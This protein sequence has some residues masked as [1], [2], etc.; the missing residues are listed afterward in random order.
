MRNVMLIAR[1]E[2]GGY[3]TTMLGYIVGAIALFLVAVLFNIYAVPGVAKKSSMVLSDFFI[4]A[5]GL[6]MIA[7][8]LVS[9]I[10]LL[11]EE[12]TRGTLTLL[13]ASPVRDVEIVFGKYLS[14]M[15]FMALFL[16][17]TF[18]MPALVL[19]YGKVSLGHI[20]CGYLG[21]LL[22]ASATVAAGLFASSVSPNEIIAAV[23]GLAFV[24]AMTTVWWLAHVTEGSLSDVFTELAWYGHFKPFSEG[25]IHLKHVLYFG[26]F[27]YVG[28]FASTR[29]IEAR[30]WR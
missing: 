9:S 21:L 29:V 25:I 12:R 30:R 10:R 23:L 8:A 27:T 18:F 5:S 26:L 2:L 15:G 24:I 1:R 4:V 13:L 22:V 17:T 16:F 3:L 6:T 19:A 20:V 14:A 7:A 11:A 28:L